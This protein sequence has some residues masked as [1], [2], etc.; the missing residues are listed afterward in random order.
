[1]QRNLKKYRRELKLWKSKRVVH[2]N[3]EWDIDL[4]T[5]KKR[6]RLSDTLDELGNSNCVNCSDITNTLNSFNIT[7]SDFVKNCTNV[8]DS[9]H[10]YSSVNITNSS[11]VK[12]SHNIWNS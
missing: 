3:N 5:L 7:S 12:D 10:I 1:M 11:S 4:L 6:R 2:L 9:N 8:T